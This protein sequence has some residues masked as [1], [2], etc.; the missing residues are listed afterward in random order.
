LRDVFG[1]DI[2]APA[3]ELSS[4]VDNLILLRFVEAE[5]EIKRVLSILKVRDS[6]Y[7]PA[8]CELIIDDSG[9]ELKKAFKDMVK[10]LSGSA[11]PSTQP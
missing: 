1:A 8:L 6:I 11:M 9:I 4:M 5:A 3:P 2:A 10:V 7:D